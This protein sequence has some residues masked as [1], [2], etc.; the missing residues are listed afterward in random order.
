M[1]LPVLAGLALSIR[2]NPL[3]LMVPGTLAC[4]LAF[5]LPVATPPNAIIFGTGRIRIAHM[6]RVGFIL[7]LAGVLVVTLATWIIGRAVFGID[8][9]VMPDWAGG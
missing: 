4:S 6:A 7:N 1:L 8:L 3:L 9:A 5:M 2:V